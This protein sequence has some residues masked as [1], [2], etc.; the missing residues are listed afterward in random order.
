MERGLEDAV[1]VPRVGTNIRLQAVAVRLPPCVI[2][3]SSKW[4]RELPSRRSEC[5]HHGKAHTSSFSARSFLKRC[6][7]YYAVKR[8]LRERD[9]ELG[10]RLRPL[11]INYRSSGRR[12]AALAKTHLKLPLSI[13]G[14]GVACD[15]RPSAT[16]RTALGPN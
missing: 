1:T 15:G 2:A 5:R 16:V 9:S 7:N 10:P 4:K 14:I 11:F 12:R 3:L 8:L 13:I 6:P